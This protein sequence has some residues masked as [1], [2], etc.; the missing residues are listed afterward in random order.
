MDAIFSNPSAHHHDKVA[1]LR[2]LL[3]EFPS[4][5]F[6]WHH[7]DRAGK[8]ER[9]A[10]VPV[11]EPA[12]ALRRRDTR[13]VTPHTYTPHDTVE[14]LPGGQDGACT[15]PAPVQLRVCCRVADAEPVD[16]DTGLCTEAKADRVPIHTDNP[17]E[18]PA[19][20]VKGGGRVVGLDLV[21]HEI[22]VVENDRAGVVGKDRN[23]DVAVPFL[24]PDL[25][26]RCLDAGLVQA[27]WE[28]VIHS[29]REDRVLAVLAPC[30]GKGF[31]LDVSRRAP[32][33][34]EIIAD[35]VELGKIERER[36]PT[37]A[38]LRVN[39]PLLSQPCELR[40]RDCEVHR[41]CG[42]KLMEPDLRDNPV[43]PGLPV[44]LTGLRAHP[45][46][47]RVCKGRRETCENVGGEPAADEVEGRG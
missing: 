24:R 8:N 44:F 20:R 32:G 25:V 21:G 46:D 6:P 33:T 26:C 16:I 12:E 35:R 10:C 36:A 11:I 1:G 23:A 13:A 40:I 34:V 4:L 31:D 43:H 47:E 18:R 15:V 7:A 42:G 17:G 19:E 14:D 27:F 37:L 38:G 30:L 3:K 29:R 41:S 28:I 39:D 5:M 22:L 9:L 45:V 2:F